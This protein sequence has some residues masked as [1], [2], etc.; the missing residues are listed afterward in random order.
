[1]QMERNK[2]PRPD[3]YPVEFCQHFWDVIKVDPMAM[4]AQLQSGELPL[5][6]LNF[7]VITLLPKKVD[8]CRIEQYRPI[9]LLNVSFNF[10]TKVGTNRVTKIAHTLIKPTQ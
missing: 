3:G 6:W 5:F 9:C 2:A 1:M 4:F 7:G 10:F 8:A